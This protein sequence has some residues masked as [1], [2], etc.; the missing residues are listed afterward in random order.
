VYTSQLMD[1]K[2]CIHF[3]VHNHTHTHTHTHNQR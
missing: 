1:N 3:Y 2:S